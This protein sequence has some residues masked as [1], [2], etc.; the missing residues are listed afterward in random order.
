MKSF[1]IT[2]ISIIILFLLSISIIFFLTY[3]IIVIEKNHSFTI[4]FSNKHDEISSYSSLIGGL[5]S[6]VSIL[7]V[8]YTILFQKNENLRQEEIKK[9]NERNDLK[10][11]IEILIIYLDTFINTIEEMEEQLTSFIK[12]ENL[13]PTII[14]NLYFNVNKNFNRLIKFNPDVVYN[15]IKEYKKDED[16][17]NIFVDVYGVID[18]YHDLLIELKDNYGKH[19]ISKIE[20]FQMIS[21]DILELYDLKAEL[22]I[23]FKDNFPTIYMSK[24]WVEITNDSIKDYYKYL[25][26]CDSNKIQNNFDL[27]NENI[28]YPYL[29][30]AINYENVL[31]NKYD[32]SREIINKISRIRK[33]IYITKNSVYNYTNDLENYK[34]KYFMKTSKSIINLKILKSE[35]E[36]LVKNP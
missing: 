7:F 30:K 22:I 31:I 33:Y 20:S 12:N 10:N 13:N 25:E 24:P 23:F 19:K 28:L 8:I 6:F 9:K 27:I 21:Y 3:N 35:L 15:A 16:W 32:I 26:D 11:K 36:A 18:F 17:K 1:K 2:T 29:S 34:N 14:N 4:D 5:L